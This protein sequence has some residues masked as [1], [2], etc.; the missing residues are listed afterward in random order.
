VDYYDL[1]RLCSTLQ[2]ITVLSDE[3]LPLFEQLLSRYTSD[4]LPVSTEAFIVERRLSL[5]ST[6]FNLFYRY[7]NYLMDAG[8]YND[9]IYTCR[10]LLETDSFDEQL[11][12]T[13]MDALLRKGSVND[14]RL[15]HQHVT[16]SYYRYLG[17]QPPDSIRDFY[18]RI[19]SADK[20]L[21]ESL[22]AICSDL[23]AG[24]RAV[25]AFICDYAIF[26]NMYSLLVRSM[27]RTELKVFVML[28]TLQGA[29]GTLPDSLS[30]NSMMDRLQEILRMSLRRGDVVSRFSASK[31]ALLLPMALRESAVIVMDRVKK[32]FY[33]EYG[34]SD[35][36]LNY[37]ISSIEQVDLQEE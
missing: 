20:T 9:A 3:T 14:A 17:T 26:R 4:L 22:N 8:R 32:N 16:E 10:R 18:N 29:D 36:V 5:H 6:C 24:D 35:I 2:D 30:L 19:A 21:E 7:L 34:R 13:L 33:S 11:Q 25:G 27:G 1:L 37:R 15:Q 31:F 12:L 28:I 23:R